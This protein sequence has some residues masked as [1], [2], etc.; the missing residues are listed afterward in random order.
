M[1]TLDATAHDWARVMSRW[2]EADRAVRAAQADINAAYR[3]RDDGM[4]DGPTEQQWDQLDALR[5]TAD[6]LQF[7]ADTLTMERFG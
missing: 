1:D 7:L 5:V 3:A 4:G 6:E 2:H